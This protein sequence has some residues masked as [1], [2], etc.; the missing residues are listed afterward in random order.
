MADSRRRWSW[1]AFGVGL[2]L[3]IPLG[4]VGLIVLIQILTVMI[5][6]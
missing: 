5:S 2:A 1:L 6:P 4:V 3:G